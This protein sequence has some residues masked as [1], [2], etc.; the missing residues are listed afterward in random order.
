MLC[1][2]GHVHVGRDGAAGTDVG[3]GGLDVDVGLDVGRVDGVNG[4]DKTGVGGIDGVD[5]VA[6][7]RVTGGCVY[8]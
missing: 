5:G 8:S 4:V 3:G 7:A 1:T 2:V 6:N